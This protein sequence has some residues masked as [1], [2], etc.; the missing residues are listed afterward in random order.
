[1]P[2]LASKNRMVNQPKMEKE[3]FDIMAIKSYESFC[4]DEISDLLPTLKVEIRDE[5]FLKYR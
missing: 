3:I 4:A 5:K 1:M 2:N